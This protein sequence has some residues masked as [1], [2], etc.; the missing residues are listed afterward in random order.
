VPGRG[1][2]QEAIMELATRAS[3]SMPAVKEAT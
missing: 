3:T 1:A 2:T